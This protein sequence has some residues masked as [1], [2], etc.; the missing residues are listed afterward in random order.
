MQRRRYQFLVAGILLVVAAVPLLL[1]DG[2]D[3]RVL[4]AVKRRDQ[5]TFSV[6]LRTKADVNAVQPDGSTALAWAVHLGQREMADALLRAGAKVNTSDEYGETPLTLA[7]ANGDSIMVQH[8]LAAGATATATRWNG[9][10]AVMLAAGAGSLDAVKALVLR[11]VDVNTADPHRGQTPLMW[12]AAEGY[13]DVVKGLVEIGANVKAVST[14]GFTPLVFAVVKNDAPSIKILL[15]AGADPNYALPSGNKP[16]MVALSYGHTEAALALMDGGA[17]LT[18]RDRAGNTPL[19]V[20]AQ[21][22]NL[23]IVNALLARKIDPNVLTPRA[24]APAGGARG[25]GGFGRGGGAGEQTPLMMAAKS[26]HEDVMRALVKAGADPSLRAQDGSTLLMAAAGGARLPTFKYAYELD[27]HVDVVLPTSGSTIMHQAVGLGT[28]TQPEVC[29]VIQFL[30]DHGAALDEMD[31][32]GRTPI[33]AA[34]FLPVDMAVDLLTKLITE[35]GEK[36]KIPS[37]R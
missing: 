3:L 27:P 16:L 18:A 28:R 32:A 36:P 29:E 9:E 7:A 15:D 21:Q 23:A 2:G 5:K 34:D 20:A 30:A 14:G 1:A 13:S 6:L 8:L 35:R 37:K 19:H 33:A 26:D 24:T 11:G 10:T 25:G 4:E 17:Q 22:G 12:A 31:K